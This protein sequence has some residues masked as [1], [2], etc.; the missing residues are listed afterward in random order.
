MQNSL[1][2]DALENIIKEHFPVSFLSC[3]DH[4]SSVPLSPKTD[5]FSLSQEEDG[6]GAGWV[7]CKEW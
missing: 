3:D 1:I 4:P 7:W 6:K 2:S 5:G